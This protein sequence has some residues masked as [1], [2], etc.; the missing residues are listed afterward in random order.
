MTLHFY[1]SKHLNYDSFEYQKSRIP[2]FITLRFIFFT[3]KRLPFLNQSAIKMLFMKV[4]KAKHKFKLKLTVM[5][6]KY[7]PEDEIQKNSLFKVKV[8]R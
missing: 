7:Q 8:T 5:K 3:L 2:F 6:Y 4:G 1:F